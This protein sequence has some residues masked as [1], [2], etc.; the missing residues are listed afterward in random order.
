MTVKERKAKL[1]A[2]RQKIEELNAATDSAMTIVN[3]FEE[4]TPEHRDAWKKWKALE[5]ERIAMI[6]Q[7]RKDEKEMMKEKPALELHTKKRAVVSDTKDEEFEAALKDIENGGATIKKG[8]QIAMRKAVNAIL[9]RKSTEK[10]NRLYNKL[11][12]LESDHYL[13]LMRRNFAA[14]CGYVDVERDARGQT[15]YYVKEAAPLTYSKELGSVGWK[16]EA[17]KATFA[18]M[19]KTY[20]TYFTDVHFAGVKI[21]DRASARKEELQKYEDRAKRV[22]D[23]ARAMRGIQDD[24]IWQK[25]D[26]KYKR[27][28]ET[29]LTL[30][31]TE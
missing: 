22:L 12:T 4:D 11:A 2:N 31:A 7:N 26:A 30:V 23:L 18:T 19:R 24:P 5:D 20:N 15:R 29:I 27:V 25:M 28:Y 9:E 1:L 21:E 16:L 3:A 10:A 6:E 8:F 13:K 14:Y 17:D